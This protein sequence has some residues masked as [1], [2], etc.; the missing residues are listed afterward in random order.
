MMQPNFSSRCL[1]VVGGMAAGLGMAVAIA[2][3]PPLGADGPATAES[4]SQRSTKS[5]FELTATDGEVVRIPMKTPPRFTVLCFLGAE[6]PLA[7]LYGP[8]LQKLAE[9]FQADGVRFVGIDS[10]RQDSMADVR[11]YVKEHRLTFPVVKD[12]DNKAADYFEATRTPEVVVLDAAEEICYRGRIDDQYEPGIARTKPERQD[13]QIALEELLAGKA[14]SVPRTAPAGCLIG[15]IRQTETTTKLT[16]CGEISRILQEHCVE[17]HRA[18]EIGPFSLTEYDEV[19]GWGETMLEVI[20][21]GRMPPWHANPK[22]GHFAN[23]RHMPDAEKESLR[24]WVSGGMP[25]GDPADL[26]EPFQTA[27]GWQLPRKPDQVIAMNNTPFK[28]PADGVVEYQY[29]VV[30]PGFKEDK[31]ITGA[32]VIPG[33]PAVVHHCIVFVR[34]PDGAEFRGVGWLTGYVPGQR[35]AMLPAGYARRVP[36]GSRLVF[37]MHYTPTGTPQTDLTKIGLIFGDDK[38]ITH[39]VSTLTA[40]NHDFEIP[41]GHPNYLVS[42]GISRL[43]AQ[44]EILAITPHMHYRGKSFRVF[45]ER[46]DQTEI[47][48]DV[49][50]YDF[51][52]QHIYELAE[53]LPLQG[54]TKLRFTARFDNSAANPFNPDPKRHVTWGDQTWEEMAIGFFEVA[55]PRGTQVQRFHNRQ[56]VPKDTPERRQKIQAFVDRFFKR[57]DANGDGV[58][59]KTELP[60]A[61]QRYGMREFDLNYDNRIEHNEIQSHAEARDF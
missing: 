24:K 22:Y 9:R 12:Y 17:C 29:F 4:A 2:A 59:V 50:R 39:E 45:A 10:N 25:F 58:I 55:V 43:P 11:E 13:L 54:I 8:R 52:W 28:V 38:D 40:L 51:N 46:G 3:E 21:D 35:T 16:Y 47:L 33:N 53:P 48:L 31:W 14:P 57:F 34:P 60:L 26:P 15:K 44:G 6:C 37:Q 42:A 41:P 32:Q 1:V 5:V 23:A 61:Q 19:T 49:P 7:R 18:G 56:K 36:A 20:D 27:A 30:D